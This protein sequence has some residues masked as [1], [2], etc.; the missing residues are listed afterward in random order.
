M[1]FK[2]GQTVAWTSQAGGSTREKIG[3]VAQVVAAGELPDRHRFPQLHR[4]AGVGSPR[5]HESYV[6]VIADKQAYWPRAAWLK[7]RLSAESE[8]RAR[9]QWTGL[10]RE[11]SW[12]A[13][14][15]ATILEQFIQSRQLL[16]ELVLF[17]RA[18]VRFAR[19]HRHEDGSSLQHAA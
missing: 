6:V 3:V 14:T 7:P 9:D 4:S 13:T 15:R 5:D 10:C 16:P 18:R 2:T 1:Q 12:D 8:L 17:A 19:E 11:T